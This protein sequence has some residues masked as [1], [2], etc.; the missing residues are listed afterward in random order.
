MNKSIFSMPD[1]KYVFIRD[2]NG[3]FHGTIAEFKREFLRKIHMRI[4]R[5]TNN[6]GRKYNPDYQRTMAYEVRAINNYTQNRVIERRSITTDF[7]RNKYGWNFL[8]DA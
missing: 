8:L 6:T 4:N 3:G 1:N 5:N 7:L 2:F